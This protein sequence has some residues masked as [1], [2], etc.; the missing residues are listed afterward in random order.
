[1]QD[2]LKKI[3]VLAMDVDGVLTDGRIIMDSNG[4]ET[5]NF[6]V[7]DGFGIVFLKKCG[8]KTAIRDTVNETMV[9]PISPAPFMAA[10][11]GLSPASR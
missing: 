2:A 7:Q 8:I 9:K 11:K 6:D 1:M 10:S 3:R 4:I 5:K